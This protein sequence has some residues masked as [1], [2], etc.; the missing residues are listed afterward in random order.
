MTVSINTKTQV[1]TFGVA[2][3]KTGNKSVPDPTQLVTDHYLLDQY[4]KVGR[5]A[6][7]VGPANK[8]I[9]P[10]VVKKIQPEVESF[11]RQASSSKP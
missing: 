8:K 4:G 10:E 11:K 3:R 9:Q 7:A 2:S 5:K 6:H 1:A